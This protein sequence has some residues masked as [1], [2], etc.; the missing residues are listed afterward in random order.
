[1][2]ALLRP[3]S[4][5]VKQQAKL[6][7]ERRVEEHRWRKEQKRRSGSKLTEGKRAVVAQGQDTTPGNV[8]HPFVAGTS[9]SKSPKTP[10]PTTTSKKTVALASVSQPSPPCTPAAQ[11]QPAK[12]TTIKRATVPV[13]VS[14]SA[15]SVQSP[16]KK[17]SSPKP[18]P[19]LPLKPLPTPRPKIATTSSAPPSSST[20]GMGYLMSCQ[21]G[22]LA[23]Q[24]LWRRIGRS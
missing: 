17:P 10:G 9:S 20:G 8:G 3:G 12:T 6:N 1:M 16:S 14:Q 22:H 4:Q 24:F 19:P 15:S 5:S 23:E 13:P 21:P 2:S 18:A 7:L 11:K